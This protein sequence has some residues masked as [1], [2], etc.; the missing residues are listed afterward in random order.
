MYGTKSVPKVF[1]CFQETF[2]KVSY[3]ARNLKKG[4]AKY[5]ERLWFRKILIF[6]QCSTI[7]MISIPLS[8]SNRSFVDDGF[9]IM[10]IN[11][12]YICCCSFI[13]FPRVSGL[14]NDQDF[15]VYLIILRKSKEQHVYSKSK[16]ILNSY[17]NT[18][19]IFLDIRLVYLADKMKRMKEKTP[20]STIQ[21]SSHQIKNF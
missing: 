5:T 3:H 8:S 19:R 10:L 13:Q 4:F 6:F 14:Q 17:I 7:G 9:W 16:E 21:K 2:P 18:S 12:L 11:N 20:I 15:E 1:F